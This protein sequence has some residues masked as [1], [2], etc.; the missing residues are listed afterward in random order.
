MAVFVVPG[1]GVG[2]GLVIL[3]GDGAAEEAGTDVD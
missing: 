1:V 3:K 2:A